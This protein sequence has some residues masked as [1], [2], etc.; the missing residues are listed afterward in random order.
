MVQDPEG[1]NP[2]GKPGMLR[3][4]IVKQRRQ[5]RFEWRFLLPAVNQEVR[6][7][8]GEELDQRLQALARCARLVRVESG[9]VDC[10]DNEL[11]ACESYA[12][13]TSLPSHPLL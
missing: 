2:C 6:L 7:R 11:S 5:R 13:F 4:E 8:I 3:I 1:V 9:E 12:P 10:L